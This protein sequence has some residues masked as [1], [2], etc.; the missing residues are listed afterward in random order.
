MA[1]ARYAELFVH[2]DD[3]HM[4][5]DEIKK[6]LETKDPNFSHQLEHR[7]IYSD[8]EIGHISVRYFIVKDSQ[9]RTVKTYGANQD[10]TDRKEAEEA[11]RLSEQRTKI[12]NQIANIFLTVPDDDIYAEVLAVVLQAMKS[13]YGL[14]GYIGDNGD[15]IIPSLTREIWSECKVP[16]KSIVFPSDTWGESLWGRAIREK[17][18]FYSNGPFRTPEGHVQIDHFLAVPILFGKE[19]IGLLSV[20]NK[21]GGYTEE[22]KELQES[23]ANFISPILNARLQRDRQ[24]RER[25]RAEEALRESEARHRAIVEVFDGLIYMCSQDYHIEFINQ[26]LVERTGYNAIGDLCYKALHDRDSVCP[27]CV[28]DQVWKGETVRW[29]VNS[30]KDNRW[31]YV[32]N[33]PI[34]HVDGSM[35]KQAMVLDITER[36]RAEELLR[37]S[38]EKYRALFEE[39][40][41]AIF[42]V[43][44][45]GKFLDVNPAGVQLSG[46]SSKEALLKADIN[47][48]FHIYPEEQEKLG[49]ALAEKGF[50]EDYELALIKKN[51]EKLVVLMTTTAVYDEKGNIIAYR[52]ILRDV[53]EKKNLE[54]QYLQSQKMEAIG[55]LA[56]GVA[57]DFNNLLMV[58]QGNVEIGLMDMDRSNPLY[59]ILNKVREGAKKAADLTQQL[60]SF[61]R[62]RVLHPRVL[63]VADLIGD[64]SKMLSRVIGEDIE[65]K[66]EFGL[67]LGHIYV[68][69]NALDQVLMN[70]VVNARN[71]M[72]QGGSLKIQAQNAQLEESFCR[73]YPELTPGEYV[74]ISV[75]D[76]GT[77]MDEDTLQR[78]FEPFFT[79]R[80]QGTGLGLAMVYGI[81]KQHHGH[82]TVSSQL[83]KG[84]RFDIYLPLHRESLVSEVLESEENVLP[85]GRETILLAEDE[86]EVRELLKLFLESLGYTVL[87]ACDGVEALEVFSA[88][89]DQIDL[90]ILDAVM[91][92]ISGPQVYEQMRTFS[93]DLNCIFLTGYSEEIIQRYFNQELEIP[94]LRKPITFYELGRK[95]REALD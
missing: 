49:R 31:Y 43:T 4:V 42:I 72:P 60:L 32:V 87:S 51:G 19:T 53:T 69:P 59:E 14:F 63:N 27:W 30:P 26:R 79:T 76:T 41:D 48:E 81:V 18:V 68:D 17:K 7:I 20:A 46:Y 94:M 23:I 15:L 33:S 13:K 40:K 92:K 38:E 24:E 88:Y 37:K 12:L 35:S 25:K 91:P 66:I 11:L 73:H 9:G 57:H 80:E 28:N 84:S 50:V 45:D 10:I 74:Q 67:N 75:V 85:R 93:S 5:A 44:P 55:I 77:G 3:R 21:D 6:A 78:I 86:K 1:S 34:Y 36:K 2:P 83:G 65:L 89:R 71:A 54:Q 8:G 29:E 82:I 61:S 95:V 16:G 39:S 47:E 62:R 56:G 22:D 58:I 52:G 70:L 90:V 64:L